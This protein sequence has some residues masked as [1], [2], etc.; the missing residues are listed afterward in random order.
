VPLNR[1]ASP[2]WVL[3]GSEHLG[4]ASKDAKGNQGGVAKGQ[5]GLRVVYQ[6]CKVYFEAQPRRTIKQLKKKKKKKKKNSVHPEGTL[7]VSTGIM[8]TAARRIRV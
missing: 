3:A 6:R 7:G 4:C 1:Q 8:S 5:K 2:V